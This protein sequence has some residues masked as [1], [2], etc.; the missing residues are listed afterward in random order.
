VAHEALLTR[1]STIGTPA[2]RSAASFFLPKSVIQA[3]ISASD[4]TG[5]EVASTGG[6]DMAGFGKLFVP[7]FAAAPSY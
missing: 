7:S 5:A 1:K 6:G 4:S 3:P 2:A